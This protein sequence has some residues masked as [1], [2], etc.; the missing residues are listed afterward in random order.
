M[1]LENWGDFA[2]V[3][4]GVCELEKHHGPVIRIYFAEEDKTIVI[5]LCGVTKISQ[6]DDIR[7]AID[8]WKDYRRRPNA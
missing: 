8:Y 2:S 5:L 4:D 7:R 1:G 6:Q 3:G